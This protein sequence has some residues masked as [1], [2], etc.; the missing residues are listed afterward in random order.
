MGFHPALI[1]HRNY[2]SSSSRPEHLWSDPVEPFWTKHGLGEVSSSEDP[3]GCARHES[4]SGNRPLEDA[5]DGSMSHTHTTINNIC[6]HGKCKHFIPNTYGSWTGHY[7]NNQWELRK[8]AIIWF[9][10]ATVQG[11]VRGNDHLSL[12]FGLQRSRMRINPLR[13]LAMVVFYQHASRP[14]GGKRSDT[15]HVLS[16]LYTNGEGRHYSNHMGK[17]ITAYWI[18]NTMHRNS[19]K[20]I[21]H[22]DTNISECVLFSWDEIS[23]SIH[24][25]W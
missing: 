14:A 25:I 19:D 24:F 23:K 6:R 9:D 16:S 8:N 21:S 15:L 7:S 1:L 10:H 13:V 17:A 4:S 12:G 22:S 20:H 2:S 18:S 11:Q 3:Y 5:L